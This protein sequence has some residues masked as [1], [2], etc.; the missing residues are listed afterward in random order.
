MSLARLFAKRIALGLTAAW[1]V[2]TSVFAAFTVS[3]DW[4]LGGIQGNL[5]YGGASEAQIEQRTE[6]YLEAR[7]FDRP[8]HEQY[9]DWLWSMTTFDWGTSLATGEPAL[10]MVTSAAWRTAM[11]VLPGIV[12]AT[13]L[14]IGIGLYSALEPNSPLSNVSVSTA[15]LLFA[16]PNFWLGGMLLSMS[17]DHFAYSPLLFEHVLPIALVASTILGGYVSYARAHSLEYASTEFIKLVESKG[18]G[19]ITIARHILHNAAIPFLSMIFSEAL[20]LLVLAVFVI[21][22]LFG[23]EGFGL[24]FFQAIE[25][26]DLPVVLGSTLFIIL[27]GIVGNILQD[28]AYTSLDPR[29]DTG[30]R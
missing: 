7:G 15:Y 29:V 2:L 28:V 10:A 12:L 9:A 11:Y 24:V 22:T 23:I 25:N 14:G 5:Q 17:D 30:T 18:A 20:A 3:R 6:A 16:V 8:L 1:I 21:E 26:R 4:I 19:S 27:V 13:L